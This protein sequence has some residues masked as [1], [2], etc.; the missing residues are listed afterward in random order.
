MTAV[1]VGFAVGVAATS[2]AVWM[3]VCWIARGVR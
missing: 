1:A 3:L 2:L